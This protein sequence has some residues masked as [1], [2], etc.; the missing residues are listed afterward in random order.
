[1]YDADY[2]RRYREANRERINQG[3]ARRKAGI[4]LKPRR[5]TRDKFE[6]RVYGSVLTESE[7]TDVMEFEAWQ[8]TQSE[9]AKRRAE[10]ATKVLA[11][12]LGVGRLLATMP[13]MTGPSSG[14]FPFT[15]TK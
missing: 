5:S 1:M 12:D 4:I 3:Y 7:R 9:R 8:R 14:P 2:W 6:I 15:R 10:R 11:L 13:Y